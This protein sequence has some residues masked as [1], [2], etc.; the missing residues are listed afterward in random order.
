MAKVNMGRATVV[1]SPLQFVIDKLAMKK[2][3]YSYEAKYHRDIED[4]EGKVQVTVIGVSVLQ[5]AEVVGEIVYRFGEGRA[6]SSGHRPDAFSIESTHIKKERGRRNAVVTTDADVA[7]K[8]AVK[9]FAPPTLGSI[10]ENLVGDVASDLESV[11]SKAMSDLR[12]IVSFSTMEIYQYIVERHLHGN[13]AVFPSSVTINTDKLSNYDKFLAAKQI[14]E[15]ILDRNNR[16]GYAVQ[17]LPDRSIRVVPMKY[18]RGYSYEGNK[19]DGAE[20][21]RYRNFE[22]LPVDLQGKIAV[23]RVAQVDDPFLDIGV[24]L[25]NKSNTMYIIE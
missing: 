15:H 19:Q 6:D 12:D 16:R 17:E 20:L 5:D 9:H 18:R 22:D 23:L 25:S 24:K 11:V 8:T 21:I 7:I 13:A 1:L 4:H 2:P 10:C 14:R 3:L